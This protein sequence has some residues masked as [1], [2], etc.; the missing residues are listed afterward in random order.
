MCIYYIITSCFYDDYTAAI[1]NSLHQKCQ[2][3]IPIHGFQK[4]GMKCKALFLTIT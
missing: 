2:V 3:F 1:I 4:H